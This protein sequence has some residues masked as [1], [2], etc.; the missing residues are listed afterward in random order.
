LNATGAVFLILRTCA[1]STVKGPD[2]FRQTTCPNR[3]GSNRTDI[4]RKPSSAGSISTDMMALSRDSGQDKTS[5]RIGFETQSK[6]DLHAALIHTSKNWT[7]SI[8]AV[9]N[10]E[11]ML[12]VS[13][14][15]ERIVSWD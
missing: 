11:Q 8:V 15:A 10:L 1:T 12:G 4:R 13:F 6:M 3:R 5:G 9:V 7:S 14:G 2:E